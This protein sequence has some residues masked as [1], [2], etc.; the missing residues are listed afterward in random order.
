MFTQDQLDT[1]NAAIAQGA[2]IVEYA[3]KKVQYRSLDDMIRT[4][5][6][7]QAELNPPQNPPTGRHYAT[8]SNGLC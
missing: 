6:L 8:F 4:R 7:M 5:D 1:L 2:L 3:D